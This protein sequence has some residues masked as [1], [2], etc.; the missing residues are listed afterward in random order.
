MY[1]LPKDLCSAAVAGKLSLDGV[2][3]LLG[4][5]CTGVQPWWQANAAGNAAGVPAGISGLRH[6]LEIDG[7][8]PDGEP[9]AV[10]PEG[11]AHHWRRLS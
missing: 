8:E 3:F 6:W 5:V 10:G 9:A 2:C 4:A 7:S 11:T 1:P